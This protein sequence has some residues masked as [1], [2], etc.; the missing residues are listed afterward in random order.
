MKDSPLLCH[1]DAINEN[2]RDRH[3]D[4]VARWQGAVEEVVETPTGYAFRFPPETAILV[5]VAEFVG[6]ERLC[7]PFFRFEIVVEANGGP[8]WLR[9]TGGEQVKTFVRENLVER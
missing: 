2:E 9:L 7:C 4:L 3:F 1:I 5:G 8:I 6:R